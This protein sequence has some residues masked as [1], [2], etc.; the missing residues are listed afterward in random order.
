MT[1]QQTADAL[2]TICDELNNIDGAYNSANSANGYNRWEHFM[3]LCSDHGFEV[4]GERQDNEDP[5]C[6]HV[7]Y[8]LVD[9][10]SVE[11]VGSR[12]RWEI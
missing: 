7:L 9:D 12:G 3:T 11:I 2:E 10:Q 8:L 5:Q 4:D 6:A 1:S